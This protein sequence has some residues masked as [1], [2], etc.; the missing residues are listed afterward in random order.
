M[1]VATQYKYSVQVAGGLSLSDCRGYEEWT[2]VAASVP[3]G[4]INV[5]VA[6]PSMI[7]AYLAGFPGNGKQ[8]PD[9]S[10]IMK[11]TYKSKKNAESP[12]PVDVPDNLLG[13][14]YMVKD[15][16]RFAHSGGWGW[17]AFNYDA[18]S[19]TFTPATSADN[20]PQE[21]DAKCG[22]AC[23]TIVNAKD[24]VFTAYPKR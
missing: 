10:K 22:F 3:Q 7:D 4:K 18:A 6:N 20:P 9:G 12:F 23:P 16:K 8:V 5:I 11:I 24:Y 21:N 14:G 1:P 15:S 17:G 19:D 2:E 13:L